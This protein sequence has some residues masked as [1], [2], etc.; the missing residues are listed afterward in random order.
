[1]LNDRD[2]FS[3][4]DYNF[5]SILEK[6]NQGISLDI[7][8]ILCIL[9][10]QDDHA[11]QELYATARSIRD[12]HFEKRVFLYGFLYLSTY[13]KNNCFFCYFRKSNTKCIR[14][15]KSIN[16]IIDAALKLQDSGV[17]LLDLTMGEDPYFHDQAQGT[18][19]LVQMLENVRSATSL[20]LMISPGVVPG[21]VL[22]D[23]KSAGVSW[24]ACYQETYNPELFGR[25]RCEQNFSQRLEAKRNAQELGF[26]TEEGIMC[27]LGERHID[28]AQSV[29]DMSRMDYDQVRAM[30]FIPQVGTPMEQY[31]HAPPDLEL[32]LIA[33]LRILNPSKLIPASLDVNG[34]KGL[35]ER[36][37]AGANVVTSVVPP[38][39]GLSGV[40]NHALDIE[41][42]NRTVDRIASE[43]K[44]CGLHIGSVE[45]YVAWMHKT[46]SSWA[47][48]LQAQ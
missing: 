12:A 4:N 47:L 14:Y 27:G 16:E 6:A 45:S 34:L 38:G 20:P 22:R 43:I 19:A 3:G 9:R 25:L 23:I 46:S 48:D 8:D 24:Y 15:R 39:C 36:L 30:T 21:D 26:L 40:A 5:T 41:N 44:S 2:V 18:Q 42:F 29:L 37:Q 13:C 10:T 17:H 32:K 31:V 7:D 35:P 1:M 28:L 33:I 11:L